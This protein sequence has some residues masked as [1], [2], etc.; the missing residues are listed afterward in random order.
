[1][2]QF[3][4]SESRA[5]MRR[6]FGL[7]HFW[8]SGVFLL[9]LLVSS[10]GIGGP[11]EAQTFEKLLVLVEQG[12]SILESEKLD[13]GPAQSSFLDCLNAEL[14]AGACEFKRGEL[15]FEFDQTLIEFDFQSQIAELNSLRLSENDDASLARDAFVKHLRAWREYISDFQF[16]LP[17]SSELSQNDLSF[18]EIWLDI[19]ENNEISETFDEL[20]SGLGNAQPSGNDEFSARI[21]DV[22]DD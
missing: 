8:W 21:I 14:F 20:C 12:E 4:H 10:C 19:Q 3:L 15:E 18:L 17:S 7:G 2:G 13:F 22:C 11:S 1:M 6:E 9:S 5:E 16:S